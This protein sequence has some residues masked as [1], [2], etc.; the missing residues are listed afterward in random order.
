MRQKNNIE[1]TADKIMLFI[2]IVVLLL[3]LL[4]LL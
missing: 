1:K 4:A 2:G 3:F